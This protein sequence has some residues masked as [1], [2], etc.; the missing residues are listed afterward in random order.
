MSTQSSLAY[1]MHAE[2]M[3]NTDELVCRSGCDAL[4][5]V[6]VRGRGW[7]AGKGWVGGRGG[8]EIEVVLNDT[9]V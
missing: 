6:Y 1:G 3:S 9:V 2:N 4:K 5:R 8:A 7:G